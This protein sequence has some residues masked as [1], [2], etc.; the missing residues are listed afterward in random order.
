MTRA[1]CR[2]DRAA[3]PGFGGGGTAGGSLHSPP[4]AGEGQGAVLRLRA[5]SRQL[6]TAPAGAG[7]REAA[8]AS[9]PQAWAGLQGEVGAKQAGSRG[10]QALVGGGSSDRA[11]G[12]WAGR[13]RRRASREEGRRA[14]ACSACSAAEARL[15]IKAAPWA[16]ILI[17]PRAA[18]TTFPGRRERAP[19]LLR[20][21]VWAAP[22]P[23]LPKP[24]GLGSWSSSGPC[25]ETGSPGG[26][27]PLPAPSPLTS[28]REGGSEPSA[29]PAGDTGPL[30]VW[31]PG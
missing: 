31:P 22:F 8:A 2:Q 21:R 3:Q 25:P 4:Q 12:G 17:L 20:G 13:P 28:T 23:R 9:T 5:L 19:W 1:A 10:Q 30:G 7:S 18:S 6:L 11:S 14:L 29:G 27:G 26:S 15:L 24:G 16:G